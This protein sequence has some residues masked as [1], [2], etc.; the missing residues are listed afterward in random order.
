[1][2]VGSYQE[3]RQGFRFMSHDDVKKVREYSKRF[4]YGVPSII[5]TGVLNF[6][7]IG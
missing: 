5:M 2:L 4:V 6:E 7:N 3:K 1:M